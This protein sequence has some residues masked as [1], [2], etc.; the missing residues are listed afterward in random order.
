M[1]VNYLNTVFIQTR[2]AVVRKNHLNI[3][4]LL[5][6]KTV[7]TV[8]I[9][10]IQ[11]IVVWSGVYITPSCMNLCMINDVA[12]NYLSSS[13]RFLARVVGPGHSSFLLRKK[14]FKLSESPD[15]LIGIVQSFVAGKLKNARNFLVRAARETQSHEII[16]QLQIGIDKLAEC[17]RKLPAI[18]SV[19]S[20]RGHEGQAALIYFNLFNCLIRSN[21]S[22]FTMKGRTRRPPLDPV[23]CLLSFFYGLLLADCCSAISSFGM[24]P[25]VG[26]LHSEY[27]GRPSLALDLMEEFRPIFADRLAVALINRQQIQE[28]HFECQQTGAWLLRESGRKIVLSAW[29][30]RKK[31]EIQHPLLKKSV[32]LGL[33]I[34]IQ[35][36]ILAKAIR[37]EL[38]NYIPFIPRS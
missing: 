31:E 36:R 11:S 25:S 15:A 7:L 18:D 10:Q 9:H 30:Q 33:V 26:F 16:N 21:Q 6:K 1:A 29:Q 32:P 2:G 17:I 35:A 23:N 28:H 24:D 5:E 27:P 14:Q 8:P 19:E 38:P 34:S 12:I 4:V 37:S 3:E 22:F 13:G 20:L